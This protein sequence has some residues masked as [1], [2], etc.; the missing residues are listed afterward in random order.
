MMNTPNTRRLSAWTLRVPFVATVLCAAL[1]SA[2]LTGCQKEEKAA[3]PPPPPEVAV[4]D[5]LAK[6]VPIHAEWVGTMDGTVNATIRSQVAGYLTKQNYKEG[7]FIKKGQVLFEIDP[8]TFQAAVAQ[9]KAVL[10]QANA[11]LE[12]SRAQV[13]VQDARWVTAKANLARVKPLADQNAVSQKD[14]DDAVGA[15]LSMRSSVLAAQ[16]AVVAAQASVGAAQASLDKAQ[17]DLDF[18]KIISPIDGIAGMAKAQMG[19][20][21]GPGSSE[22]L[23]TVSTVDPIKVYVSVSEQEYLKASERQS[24]RREKVPVEMILSDGSVYAQKGEFAFADRQVDVRT[25]TIRVTVLFPNPSNLMRPGQ[26]A[27][28]RAEMEIRKGAITVPQRAVSEVQGRYLAAVVG[29]DNKVSIKP[30]KAGVRF[31][32]L[33]VIDEGLQAGQKVVAEGTQKVRDGM[34]VSPKPFGAE[35]P[36]GPGAEKPGAKPEAKPQPKPEKR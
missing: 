33:W 27:R 10:D 36:A 25:G 5:V 4:V 8:R 28:L 26:F 17:L 29:P 24:A 9:A 18:T 2:L 12:Q 22:E 21:V 31:G 30:V 1:A 16:A 34:V 23:T 35:A 19:N 14:L 13:A 7:D 11:T 32:Q 6:D 15:E 20:L 3:G